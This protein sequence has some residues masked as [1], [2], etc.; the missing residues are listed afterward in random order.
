MKRE[1]LEAMGLSKE[2][3]DQ[4]MRENGNDIN[5]AKS[6]YSDYEDIKTQLNTANTT[7]D[8]LKGQVGDSEQLNKTIKA[9]ENTIK[10]LEKKFV[11]QAKTQNLKDALAGKVQDPEYLIYLHGGI[12][13]F[14][15]GEDNKPIG[16]DDILVPYKE[17]KPTLFVENKPDDEGGEGGG[18]PFR[19]GSPGKTGNTGN[20]P[21]DNQALANAFGLPTQQ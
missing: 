4:I 18:E 6:A 21:V 13:K 2:Q 7:I 19:F 17:S 8:T 9:H 3:V 10:N 11:D 12:D 14:I 16:L 1:F 5:A 15:F 20:H